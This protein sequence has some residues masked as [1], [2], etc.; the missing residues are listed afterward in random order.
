M[1][2]NYF[3]RTNRFYQQGSYGYFFSNLLSEYG[4]KYNLIDIG[5]NQGLYSIIAAKNPMCEKVIGYE[6]IPDIFDIFKRNIELNQCADKIIPVKAAIGKNNAKQSMIYDSHHSGISSFSSE[7]SSTNTIS[8]DV[9]GSKDI[10][11]VLDKISLE[12]PLVLKIDVEGFELEVLEVL[13]TSRLLQN[14]NLLYI[15]ISQNEDLIHDIL[16]NHKFQL[17]WRNDVGQKDFLYSKTI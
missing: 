15:E 3:D 17:I 16:S 9:L 7:E 11:A 5:A 2:N 13:V 1:V 10:D 14:V 4:E 8:I 12:V 6:P